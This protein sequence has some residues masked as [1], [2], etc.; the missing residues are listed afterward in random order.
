MPDSAHQAQVILGAWKSGNI[1]QFCA[2]LEC[3]EVSA[4]ATAGAA[5]SERMELLCAIAAD[6][7]VPSLQPL[8]DDPGNI[9]GSLLRH[10]AFSAEPHGK[11]LTGDNATASLKKIPALVLQ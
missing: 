4:G 7:R 6:L 11:G 9:Y 1:Q 3:V 8:A 2:E 10:L 5:E